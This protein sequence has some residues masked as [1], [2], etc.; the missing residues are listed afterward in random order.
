MD[1]YVKAIAAF[2]GGL[3]PGA[4]V[5]I[6]ALFGVHMDAVTVGTLIGAVSPVLAL[7]ATWRAP[8]N[9]VNT[10]PQILPGG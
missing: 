10:P 4:V 5:G 6:L 8:A 1:K 3:T 7:L 2:L 9:A